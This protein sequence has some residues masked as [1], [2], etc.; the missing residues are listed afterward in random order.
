MQAEQS[1]HWEPESLGASPFAR[2]LA[3]AV[4]LSSRRPGGFLERRWS[5]MAVGRYW[6]LTSVKECSSNGN[7]RGSSRIVRPETRQVNSQVC[8]NSSRQKSKLLQTW[9]NWYLRLIIMPYT[10]K[11]RIYCP[12]N[13]FSQKLTPFWELSNPELLPCNRYQKDLL[14]L[15]FVCFCFVFKW[16]HFLHIKFYWVKK[17]LIL[18]GCTLIKTLLKFWRNKL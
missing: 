1:S 10:M 18:S 13:T 5:H 2:L 14:L 7:S 15:L 17:D 3:W 12:L 8:K 16:A 6:L 4:G 11:R 9:L